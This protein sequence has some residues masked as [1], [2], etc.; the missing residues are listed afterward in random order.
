MA[1]IKPFKALRPVPELVSQVAALPYDVVTTREAA[2][3]VK[4]NK[5][6][7]LYIDRPEIAFK[8]PI[9][10]YDSKVYEKAREKLLDMIEK[11]YIQ[12]NKPCFYIYQLNRQNKIQ[13][14]IVACT[15]IDDYLNNV[16][17]KHEHTLSEKEQDRVNHVNYTEAHTGPILMTYRENPD[18]TAM[19]DE[20]SMTQ[21]AI[22]NFQ[23]DDNVTQTV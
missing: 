12:D 7:F 21:P 17:K 4:D 14:G 18:I 22:Y 15:S 10:P 8:E 11:I 5:Y 19:I 1:I 20:W 2:K 3:I 16:I 23:T 13:K 9:N 6:S